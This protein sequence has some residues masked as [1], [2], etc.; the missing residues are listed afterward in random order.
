[1]VFILLI[2]FLVTTS[3]TKETGVEI[4]RPAAATAVGKTHATILI[5]VTK[6]DTIH[7]D[8]R[9]IYIRAVRVNVE[10]ALAEPPEGQVVIVADKE[11]LTGLVI[12]V[13]DDCKLAGAQNISISASLPKDR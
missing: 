12:T 13:M 2:F 8:H 10:Q 9:Q 11:S 4:S 3:F 7:L 5:G 1:M 6:E